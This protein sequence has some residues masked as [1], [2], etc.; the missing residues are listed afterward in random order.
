MGPDRHCNWEEANWR[1][2]SEGRAAFL[3]SVSVAI[4]QELD[5]VLLDFLIF[6]E[7]ECIDVQYP[8]F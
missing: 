3:L 1:E 8:D 6:P 5:L 2:S 7:M 4:G